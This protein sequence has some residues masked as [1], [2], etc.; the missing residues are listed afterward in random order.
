MSSDIGVYV[1]IHKQRY[2]MRNMQAHIR[3]YV[4]ITYAHIH[5]VQIVQT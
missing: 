2:Y 3:T 5:T 1:M 4:H